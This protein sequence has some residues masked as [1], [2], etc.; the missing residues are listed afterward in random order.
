MLS[1]VCYLIMCTNQGKEFLPYLPLALILLQWPPIATQQEKR[2][3]RDVGVLTARD[4]REATKKRTD[5]QNLP[6][7]IVS[8]MSPESYDHP[9][10]DVQLIQTHISFVLVAGERVY[11]FK[12]PVDFGFLDFS[13][14]EKRAYFC[15]QEVILNR[16][17]CPDIYLGRVAVQRNEGGFTLNGGGEMVAGGAVG[18]RSGLGLGGCGCG[19]INIS[20]RSRSVGDHGQHLLAGRI[21][22]INGLF[23]PAWDPLPV[24]IILKCLHI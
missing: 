7:Y 12:K 15:E 4:G 2:I 5:M 17:L 20:D 11:K 22:Y 6:D 24:D 1:V 21:Q 14:L 9:V 16:R 13:T 8:L 18:F 23:F 19:I 3:A 10:D